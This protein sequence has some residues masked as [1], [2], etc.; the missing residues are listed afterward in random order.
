MADAS[1]TVYLVNRGL[2]RVQTCASV[3]FL[4]SWRG[5]RH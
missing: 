3:V 1:D 5:Q 2:L 4:A